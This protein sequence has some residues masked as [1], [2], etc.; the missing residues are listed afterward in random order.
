MFQTLALTNPPKFSVD[1]IQF[2]LTGRY[3]A[4]YGGRGINVIEL[5]RKW[6][7]NETREGDKRFLLAR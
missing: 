1:T 4:L 7:F 3:L 5:P 6:I 2:S